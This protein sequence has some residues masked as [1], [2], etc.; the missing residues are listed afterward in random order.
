M[1][2][3]TRIILATIFFIGITLCFL[4]FTGVVSRYLGWMEKMQLVPAV[5]A[6]NVGVVALL[7]VVTLVFGRVYCSVICPMGVMQDIISWVH[8]RKKKARVRF[9]YT[10]EKRVLRYCFLAVFVL[11]IVLGMTSIAAL[12]APYSAFGRIA[13]NIFAPVYAGVNNYLASVAEHYDSYAFY[14]VDVWLKSGISLAVAVATLERG[15]IRRTYT[16]LAKITIEVPDVKA[17]VGVFGAYESLCIRYTKDLPSKPRVL[18]QDLKG[19]IPVDITKDV[20]IEG[21]SITVPGDV[22]RRV[23]LMA[24]T[25]GDKSEPGMVMVVR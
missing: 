14:S 13:A 6:L 12:I 3:K 7:L 16:P 25:K 4:D 20:K 23:G 17:P 18:A 24:A 22:I 11:L 9:G 19:K 8:N 5:L 10:S 2:R 1:L 21:R 15:I